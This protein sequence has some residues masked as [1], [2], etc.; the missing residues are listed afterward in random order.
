MQM[1][2]YGNDG[3]NSRSDPNTLQDLR[4]Y[5]DSHASSSSAHA[6]APPIGP[7]PQEKDAK[8]MKKGKSGNGS[9]WSLGDPNCRGG[10]GLQATRR[11]RLKAK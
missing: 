4:C 3:H 2:S 5:S 6:E 7:P 8:K 9:S 11:T 10:R 1:Q